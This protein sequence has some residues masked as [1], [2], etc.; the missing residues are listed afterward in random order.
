MC[1]AGGVPR[2]L[3]AT[4]TGPECL[5][6]VCQEDKAVSNLGTQAGG[7]VSWHKISP[8]HL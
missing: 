8:E 6:P 5:D 2:E 4:G 1:P 3:K 7:K